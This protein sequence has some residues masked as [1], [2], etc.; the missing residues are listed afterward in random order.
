[1]AQG[2]GGFMRQN[3]SAGLLGIIFIFGTGPASAGTLGAGTLGKC[4]QASWHSYSVDVGA[5]T[6]L[7]AKEE[8]WGSKD[9]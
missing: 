9:P 3:I 5:V 7:N 6:V 1:M 8:K 4:N 2:R